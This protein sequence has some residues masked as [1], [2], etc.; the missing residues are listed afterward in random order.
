MLIVKIMANSWFIYNEP[1]EPAPGSFTKVDG[2][3]ACED[4]PRLCAIYAEVGDDNLPKIT[5]TLRDWMIWSTVA[6]AR[7]ANVR[8]RLEM[9]ML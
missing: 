8:M 6:W 9:N 4:G 2:T 3:P 1:G 5:P 7:S